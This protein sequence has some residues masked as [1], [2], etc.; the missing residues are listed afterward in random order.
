MTARVGTGLVVARKRGGGWSAPS[1]LGSFG[2]GWGFQVG[3]EVSERRVLWRRCSV[4]P[5]VFLLLSPV[6]CCSLF[7][8]LF[9]CP[10]IC[11]GAHRNRNRNRCSGSTHGGRG[12]LM[13]SLF[14]LGR[15]LSRHVF[16]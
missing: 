1:A 12:M 16:I 14:F 8:A 3:G 4:F 13:L 10:S 9:A 5:S 11:V 2:L 15:V 7:S 6:Q